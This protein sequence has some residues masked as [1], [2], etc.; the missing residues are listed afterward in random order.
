MGGAGF[1][2]GMDCGIRKS[3]MLEICTPAIYERMEEKKK[4]GRRRIKRDEEID[5]GTALN[6][7]SRTRAQFR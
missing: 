1:R 4:G 6:Q 3:V 5:K 2:A 7:A